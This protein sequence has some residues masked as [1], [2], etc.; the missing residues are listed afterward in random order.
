VILLIIEKP[1]YSA[2]TEKIMAIINWT[3][4]ITAFT[5]SILSPLK[6][7]IYMD[8]SVNKYIVHYR[9]E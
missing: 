8:Q 5:R 9:D 7:D 1:I 2:T 3:N 4:P 6:S